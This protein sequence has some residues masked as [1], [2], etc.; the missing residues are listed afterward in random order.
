MAAPF[1]EL[2]GTHNAHRWYLPVEEAISVGAPEQR[3]L[4]GGVGLAAA[5]EA[6][7]RTC[8]RPVVWA[9]AQYLSYARPGMV[10][11]LD[12]RAPVHGKHTSQ[13]R[14]IGHV[15]EKEII[16]V[17]AALGVRDSPISDQ[18]VTAPPAPPPEDCPEAP[19]WRD[20]AVDLKH[21]LEVRVVS[22]RYPDGL[23][24]SGVRGD[25]RVVFWTRSKADGPVGPEALA[26][27][28]DFVSAG[29]GDAAGVRVG[30]NS[31]DNTIRFVRREP[32]Q[33][34]LCEVAIQSMH[35]GI[36]HGT[37]NLFAQNG[38][39]MACASQSMLMRQRQEMPSVAPPT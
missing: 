38:V 10:L 6:L 19:H 25:G 35:D 9:T 29:L 26:I 2:H 1:F 18:W 36:A 28:A 31:L 12:V 27:M 8:Q 34:V 24:L 17:N 37:M 3:F 7:E 5:I 11:D 30:G 15:G 23:D 22:G 4:F 32:T 20:V 39:L 21:A 33:W 14:V 16:V 13:A